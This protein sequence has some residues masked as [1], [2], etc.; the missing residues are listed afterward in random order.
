MRTASFLFIVGSFLNRNSI[1]S[2]SPIQI[3]QYHDN[4]GEGMPNQPMGLP[5]TF[6]ITEKPT[7]ARGPP[8]KGR[9][10]EQKDCQ[11]PRTTRL[12]T[13]QQKD[14]RGSS[15]VAFQEEVRQHGN[16]NRH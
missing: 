7:C 11:E 10:Q 16:V 8:E 13:A 9:H 2:I 4:S 6:G 1:V 5:E 15:N 3:E 12:G 14:P